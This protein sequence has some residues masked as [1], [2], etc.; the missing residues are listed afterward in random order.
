MGDDC[1]FAVIAKVPQNNVDFFKTTFESHSA[2]PHLMHIARYNTYEVQ[3]D[4]NTSTVYV[5]GECDHSIYMCMLPTQE[6]YFFKAQIANYSVEHGIPVRGD[7]DMAEYPSMKMATHILEV[8]KQLNIPTLDIVGN[9]DKNDFIEIY[10]IV[11]GEMI[12]ATICEPYGIYKF[13]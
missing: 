12:N 3:H 9:S 8:C 1:S 13:A 10:N 2:G 11:N 4:D 6:S 7:I 5:Y